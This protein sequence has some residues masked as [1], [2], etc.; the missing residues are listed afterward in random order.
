MLRYSEDYRTIGIVATYFFVAISSWFYFPSEW[1]LGVAVVALNCVLSFLCATMVHNS[2]HCPI[3]KSKTVN[4]I[5]QV[6]LT[7]TYG[8]PVSAYVPGHNFSHHKYVQTEKDNIR[9]FKMR[10]KWNFLN[11]LLFLPVMAKD[12]ISSEKRFLKRMKTERS[13]WYRQYCIESYSINIVKI[14]LLLIDWKM[15]LFVVFIPHVYAAWG[16]VG[17]NYWQH[18]GCDQTHKYNHSRTFTNKLLNFLTCNNGYH[19]AHHE[20]PGLHW[21]K[22]PEY[23]N[24]NIAPHIHPNLNRGS[25]L[26]YLWEAHIWPGKRLD[27]LGN[28]MILPAKIKDKDWVAD[29][30]VSVANLA[31]MGAEQ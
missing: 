9:T 21:S 20:I 15:F 29:I 8:H 17:T 14:S 16:I 26:V 31:Q 5:F 11:Q 30:P 7:F 13:N 3:F 25:L 23:H 24:K 12:I 6:I 2:I 28:P 19:G 1:Y 22:Y 10:F 27:Y 4:K 18:D